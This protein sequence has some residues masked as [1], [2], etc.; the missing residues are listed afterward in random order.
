MIRDYRDPRI[1][2]ALIDAG[3][4]ESTIA[5]IAGVSS[6]AV[7]HLVNGGGARLEPLGP[8]VALASPPSLCFLIDYL[9]DCECHQ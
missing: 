6:A 9:N 8:S 1:V 7:R 3:Y 4:S 2:R 5:E